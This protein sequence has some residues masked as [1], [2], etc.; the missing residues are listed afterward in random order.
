MSAKDFVQLPE[1]S[2][3]VHFVSPLFS[4]VALTNDLIYFRIPG[5]VVVDYNTVYQLE[6][7]VV[8][9]ES[10]ITGHDG[11][12]MH[13]GFYIGMPIDIRFIQDEEAEEERDVEPYEARIWG[14]DSVLIGFPAAPYAFVHNF[15]E[16][17]DTEFFPKTVQTLDE[18]RNAFL[19][20]PKH[21]RKRWVLLKFPP[22]S[23]SDD[24]ELSCKEIYIN[25]DD[26]EDKVTLEIGFSP[27]YARHTA[28]D[29]LFVSGEDPTS[30]ELGDTLDWICNWYVAAK[31]GQATERKRGKPEKKQKPSL[32]SSRFLQAALQRQ[33]ERSGGGM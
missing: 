20:K 27:V 2:K 23:G 17:P 13:A 10:D 3:H 31:D 1:H 26:I 9:W 33:A 16:F 24:I 6:N 14:T 32:K 25:P 8:A 12:S 18:A 15:D 21:L 30:S 22:R 19:R 11:A 7:L 5:V 28:G 4:N 29:R